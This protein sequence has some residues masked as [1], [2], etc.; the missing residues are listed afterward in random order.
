MTKAMSYEM[1]DPNRGNYKSDRLFK[2]LF[3]RA[4]DFLVSRY[5]GDLTWCEADYEAFQYKVDDVRLVFYPHRSAGCN[6][7]LRV[8]DG[9]SKNKIRAQAIMNVIQYDLRKGNNDFHQLNNH[10]WINTKESKKE[11]DRLIAAGKVRK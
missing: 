9:G 5:G 4:K 3:L 11:Q 6:Y 7:N 8:R 2:E 1:G 10:C